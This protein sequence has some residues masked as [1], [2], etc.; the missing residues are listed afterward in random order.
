VR[1]VS[2]LSNSAV[3]L[4]I[5][6]PLIF[7]KDKENLI[8]I[9]AYGYTD[10]LLIFKINNTLMYIYLIKNKLNLLVLTIALDE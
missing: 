5:F 7:I 2:S 6:I 1:Q 4:K 8:I 10:K 3:N 9:R